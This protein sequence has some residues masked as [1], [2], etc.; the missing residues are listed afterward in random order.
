MVLVGGSVAVSHLLTSAPIFITQGVRYAVSALLLL[1]AARAVGAPLVRPRGADWLWLTGIAATG[2]VLFNVA[3]VR[4]VA[5]AEPAVIAVAVAC[6]PILLGVIGPLV[7]A[8]RPQLRIVVAAVVV[9]AGA[10]LVDG[11]GHSD[12]QGIG[13]AAVALAC[14]ACFTLF[15]LPVLPRI[16]AWGVS[17]HSVWIGAVMLSVLAA[18][19]ERHPTRLTGSELG[20]LAYLAVFVTVLA[21]V[22]WYSTVSALGPDKVGLLTGVAPVSAAVIGIGTGAHVPGLLVWVGVGVVIAGLAG[23]L[24][25]RGQP[26]L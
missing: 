19:F 13:W 11:T 26:G 22:L 21:F 10:V 18:L 6:V 12:A 23:G 3:I 16:G 14:E 17:I 9:T 25:A 4:G 15:A 8:R 5:H 7:Q 24:G 1:A 20:A 2:L